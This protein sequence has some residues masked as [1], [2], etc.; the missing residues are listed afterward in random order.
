MTDA[1]ACIRECRARF[2]QERPVEA[3]VV[4]RQL[5]HPVASVVADFT[6]GHRGTKTVQCAAAGAHRELT[7]ATHRVQRTAGGLRR[8]ALIHVLVSAEDHVRVEVVERLPDGLHPSL[9]SVTRARICSAG[10]KVRQGALVG[11]GGQ[12]RAQPFFLSRPR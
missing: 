2:R 7:D 12:I 11:V 1:G 10:M 4:E 3:S 6:V 8:E 9:A 5:Q